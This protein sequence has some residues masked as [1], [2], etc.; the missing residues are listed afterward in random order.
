MR[1][2]QGGKMIKIEVVNTLDKTIKVKPVITLRLEPIYLQKG[3]SDTI[4]GTMLY[5][6]ID[7]R[8]IEK[9]TLIIEEGDD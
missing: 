2:I 7:E 5:E 3:G 1:V 4:T 9:V 8:N 6:E